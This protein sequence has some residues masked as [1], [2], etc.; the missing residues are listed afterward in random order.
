[1]ALNIGDKAPDF[2]LP[3]TTGESITLSKLKTP[4]LVYF[5]PRDD[6]PG[7]TKEACDFRDNFNRLKSAGVTVLGISK[8]N[9]ASHEKFQ[10][11]FDLNFP[12]L[13][14]ETGKTVEAYGAWVEKSMYGKKYMGIERM[15]FL[16]DE[17]G[18]IAQLWPK[19]KVEGHVD[20]VI[21][22]AQ[23]LKTSKAA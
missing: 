10:K 7:C 5:Y 21:D 2:T 18:K 14:D 9:L 20:E 23:K 1:M 4:A 3:A 19:V 13:S 6:T 15:T 11:K 22:A 16:V 17:N 8:D 12:L